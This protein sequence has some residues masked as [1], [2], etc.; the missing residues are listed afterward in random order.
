MPVGLVPF[1]ID[2]S[3]RTS[4]NDLSLAPSN[5]AST[6]S[7]PRL[8]LS[9]LLCFHIAICCLSLIY[10]AEFYSG[11]NIIW[12]DQTRLYAAVLNV[13]LFAIALLPFIFCRFSFGY[14]LGF[15]FYTMILDYLWLTTFSKFH[16][17]HTL[18]A[19]SAFVSALAF[20][21]PAL[22]ITSPIKQRLVLSARSLDNLLSFIL[23]LAATIIAV[24]AFYNFKLVGIGEIYN[25][26]GK[27]EFPAWLRYA[28]G[29][30]SNTLLPFAFACFVARGNRRRA[31]AVLLLL[32]LFY[33]ITLTKLALFAPFWLLFLVL[34]S[35][36][37]Q[38]RT[39]VV[40]SLFLP[41][42]TGVILAVLVKSGAFSYEQ[43]K[44]YFGAVN[45]RM[46]AFPSV[47]LDLYND[48]FA[49]HDHT[50]F[51][52]IS[53]LKPFVDCP[54]HEYLSIVMA[55]AYQLGNLN[56]SLFATEGVASVGPILAPLI[57]LACGLV[58][59]LGNR[60]SSGLPSEFILLSGGILPQVFL[61]VPL[62]TTLLT[63]GAAI[64]FLLWY[65]T[66]RAMIA[67]DNQEA[68]FARR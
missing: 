64:L 41:I 65:V 8:R 5:F 1:G 19:V 62:T 60:L 38:A 13:A 14:F 36:F 20:L 54:Y 44:E 29:A 33:P 31:A 46:I 49:A 3:A 68:S 15:Y 53:F 37:F 17:D 51:C 11:S 21:V 23:I 34:L 63:N 16:Y 45:F 52:Q 18:A 43:I 55:R 57:V 9:L 4:M 67:G 10:V 59:S 32:L 6:R 42:L 27:I 35:R 56:A 48:F 25:F 7:R 12:F 24:G 30:S 47:A 39:A 58:I 22:F 61:N 26:R 50:Y 2:N 40:L 28:I 66:P